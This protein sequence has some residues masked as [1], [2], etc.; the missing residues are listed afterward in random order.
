MRKQKNPPGEKV[1]IS[2]NFCPECGGHGKTWDF[3]NPEEP[4]FYYCGLCKGK[5]IMNN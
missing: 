2:L 1:S 3:M 5:S 4:V